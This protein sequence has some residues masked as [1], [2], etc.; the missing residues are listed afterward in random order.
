[1]GGWQGA[2][3]Q[4]PQPCRPPPVP[5]RDHSLGS[6]AFAAEVQR[7]QQPRGTRVALAQSADKLSAG[8]GTPCRAA[9]QNE[10]GDSV[11]TAVSG[12]HT[13]ARGA[14][15]SSMSQSTNASL[16]LLSWQSWYLG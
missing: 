16:C 7:D 6:V 10:Q 12:G 2:T 9:R 1:M 3:P 14:R 11:G 15:S 5:K 4:G 13:H 8:M